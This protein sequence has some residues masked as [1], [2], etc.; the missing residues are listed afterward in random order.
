MCPWLRS[1]LSCRSSSRC[2]AV[3]TGSSLSLERR[4]AGSRLVSG[5]LREGA[6]SLREGFWRVVLS[7]SETR[8]V[9]LLYIWVRRGVRDA[10]GQYRVCFSF[11]PCPSAAAVCCFPPTRR[12]PSRSA[13]P[14][15][16]SC[17]QF[18]SGPPRRRGGRRWPVCRGTS[19]C[20]SPSRW[21]CRRWSR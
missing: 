10:K 12:C 11:S 17:R 3:G 19:A 5:S 21:S 14:S 1:T 2:G 13:W 20:G 15:W 4:W 16:R 18:V 8:Q 7:S 6:V 9:S